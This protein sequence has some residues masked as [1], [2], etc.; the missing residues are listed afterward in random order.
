MQVRVAF[1]IFAVN[2]KVWN[3]NFQ[4]FLFIQNCCL[5]VFSLYRIVFT[6]KTIGINIRSHHTFGIYRQVLSKIV[7]ILHS[8]SFCSLWNL[9]LDSIRALSNTLWERISQNQSDGLAASLF[10]SSGF[11]NFELWIMIWC[12]EKLTW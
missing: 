7:S 9:S 8:Q 5:I 1:R 11:V 6:M 3:L 10:S 12:S 2:H 4:A